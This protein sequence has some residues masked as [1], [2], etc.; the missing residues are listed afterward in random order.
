MKGRTV[1]DTVTIKRRV[2]TIKE[3]LGMINSQIYRCKNINSSAEFMNI[4]SISKVSI[5]K[6]I[7]FLKKKDNMETIKEGIEIL[8]QEVSSWSFHSY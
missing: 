4:A 3:R 5:A 8:K 1:T 7:N 2:E 6:K